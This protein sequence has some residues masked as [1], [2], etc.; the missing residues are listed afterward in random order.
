MN[1]EFLRRYFAGNQAVAKHIRVP[2]GDGADGE[3]IGV[4]GDVKEG[5]LDSQPAPTV[6]AI[7]SR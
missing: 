2:F 5:S 6:Y 3:I 4:V 7:Q 1:Q